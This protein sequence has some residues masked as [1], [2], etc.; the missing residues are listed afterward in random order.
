MR[1]LFLARCVSV[2]WEMLGSCGRLI[3]RA[4]D[5]SLELVPVLWL[6]AFILAFAVFA[7]SEIFSNCVLKSAAV[8]RKPPF[9]T[10][11]GLSA[12]PLIVAAL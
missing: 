10:S 11:G 2:F 8:I 7:L 1:G 9:I 12:H 5:V 6:A 4:G 3:S